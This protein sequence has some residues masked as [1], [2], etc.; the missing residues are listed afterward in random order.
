MVWLA[1]KLQKLCGGAGNYV[2]D[3]RLMVSRGEE[4][5]LTKIVYKQ[6]IV[7]RCLTRSKVKSSEQ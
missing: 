1:G 5:A 3:Q 2:E 4:S 7:D 6:T